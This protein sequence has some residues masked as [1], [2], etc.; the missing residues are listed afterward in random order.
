MKQKIKDKWNKTKAIK[1]RT[2]PSKKV[3]EDNITEQF[4]IYRKSMIK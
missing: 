4:A 2:K 3:V 1:I